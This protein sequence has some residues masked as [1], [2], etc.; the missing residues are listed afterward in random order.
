MTQYE[1]HEYANL[2]PLIMAE[3]LKPIVEDI[4]KHGIRQ[5]IVLFEGKIL[6]G[7]NRYRAHQ[8]LGCKLPFIFFSG[9]RAA[10]LDYVLSTNLHRR[11][12]TDQQRAAIA[13]D[14]ANLGNGERKSA[15][16]NGE[17]AVTQA[18]AAKKLNVS[19]RS[20]E[21]AVE[22]K[23]ADPAAHE[24][25]KAGRKVSKKA[26]PEPKAKPFNPNWK[27]GDPITSAADANAAHK[28]LVDAGQAP[29]EIP[30]C[31]YDV[32]SLMDEIPEDEHYEEEL[33]SIL[34]DVEQRLAKWRMNKE[35]AHDQETSDQ[36][37]PILD[38]MKSAAAEMN[39]LTSMQYREDGSSKSATEQDTKSD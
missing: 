31:A 1:F 5:P 16:P 22:R 34:E 8:S 29:D 6:D 24:A 11:H 23:K 33:M 28:S 15:S 17:G 3:E 18:Q 26:K 4:E 37:K 20:V 36:V 7:R 27:P 13:A 38:Q 32:S 21:R 35:S 39:K 12:L 14:I 30:V 19:K 2:F 9:D 25:V 10:A